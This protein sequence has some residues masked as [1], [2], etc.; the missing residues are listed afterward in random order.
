[1]F[2]ILAIAVASRQTG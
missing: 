1:M 2:Y